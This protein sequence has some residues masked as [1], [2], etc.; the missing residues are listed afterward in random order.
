MKKKSLVM[1]AV[2]GALATSMFYALPAIA[3]DTIDANSDEPLQILA[4]NGMQTDMN[5]NGADSNMH[6]GADTNNTTPPNTSTN[7][8]TSTPQNQQ[9]TSGNDAGSP[10]TAT[11]DDDY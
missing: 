6:G 5:T 8:D 7:L 4:D 1:L 10:D 9:S 11:G 3:D 2:S